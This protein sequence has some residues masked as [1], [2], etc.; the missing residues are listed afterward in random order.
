VTPLAFGG[1]SAV[2]SV[3]PLILMVVADPFHTCL[4]LY[5]PPHKPLCASALPSH[6]AL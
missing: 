2:C 5:T 6:T 1:R 4:G 3:D